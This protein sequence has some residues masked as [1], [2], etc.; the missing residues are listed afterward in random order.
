MVSTIVMRIE[1]ERNIYT[2]PTPANATTATG[3]K[4]DQY[5]QK[6][7]IFCKMHYIQNMNKEEALYNFI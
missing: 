1:K 2:K 5:E 3:Y 4:N 7:I 6:K